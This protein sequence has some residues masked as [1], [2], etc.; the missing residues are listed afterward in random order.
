MYESNLLLLRFL[1]GFLAARTIVEVTILARIVASMQSVLLEP[2]FNSCLA[3]STEPNAWS[4]WIPTIAFESLMFILTLNKCIKCL[5]DR[6]GTPRL[7][8]I[9]LRDSLVFFGSIL[10][11]ALLNCFLWAYGRPTLINAFPSLH[12]SLG[13]IIGCRMLMNAQEAANTRTE[14]NSALQTV[15]DVLPMSPLYRSAVPASDD[16]VITTV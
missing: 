8:V 15:P 7:L 14:Y 4:Y 9:M 11:V 16:I 12:T 3:V 10:A 13:A 1:L 6:Y 2:P 5:M